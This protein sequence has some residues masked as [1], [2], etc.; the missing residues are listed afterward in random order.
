MTK[1]VPII[2]ANNRQINQ[3]IIKLMLKTKSNICGKMHRSF[4]VEG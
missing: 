3:I 1:I 4:E 2:N